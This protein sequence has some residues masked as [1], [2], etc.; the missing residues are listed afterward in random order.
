MFCFYTD[1]V[2]CPYCNR[3]FNEKAAERHINF[4]KDQQKRLPAKREPT[5]EE[6]AR[7]AARQKVMT[8]FDDDLFD[9]IDS[10]RHSQQFFSHFM[11]DFPRSN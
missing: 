8:L 5:A 6:K 1:Y 3:R 9:S 2:S 7:A 10:L 4:C 11:A